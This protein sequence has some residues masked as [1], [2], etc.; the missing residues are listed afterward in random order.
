MEQPVGKKTGNNM[1]RDIHRNDPCP[2]GSGKKYKKCCLLKEPVGH[3]FTTAILGQACKEA[4]KLLMDYA[5]Q[6]SDLFE[7]PPLLG[8]PIPE[9]PQE[10]ARKTLERELWAIWILYLWFPED[11]SPVNL[12]SSRTLAAQFLQD[13]GHRLDAMV[14]RYIEAARTEPFSFWQA[15]S[16]VPETGVCLKDL[17]TGD[18]RFAADRTLSRLATR[19]DIF[20]THVVGLDGQFILNGVG[21]YSLPPFS[22]RQRIVQLADDIRAPGGK[23]PERTQLLRY[24]AELI[25]CY[26]DYVDELLDPPI[27]EIRNKDGHKLVIAKSKYTFPPDQRP[28][29]IET[30]RN[31]RNLVES[32]P[33]NEKDQFVWVGKPKSCSQQDQILK[34]EIAI[35]PD[36]LET[37][38][39]SEMRDKTI[40]RRLLKTFGTIL[41]HE[42]TY[43]E[44][45]RPRKGSG[46]S[47]MTKE[48]K[49]N[50]FDMS[51]LSPEESR[52]MKAHFDQIHMRW[53][54]ES[55]PLLGG[56]TP[57]QVARSP[58]GK[59]QIAAMINDWQHLHQ[60]VQ[61]GPYKFDF[62]KLRA[63]LGIPLLGSALEL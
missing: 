54:D 55:V 61:S 59:E 6:H 28:R 2:C 5:T 43:L 10:D 24:Q 37:E 23:P 57:R 35:G 32:N 9:L 26:F 34:G 53:L 45:F 46:K 8:R 58:K 48:E 7:T 41:T 44:P 4:F 30:L 52:Q 60:R 22:F 39:N 38:C 14:R 11:Y 62:N 19:G 16:V 18:E 21:P 15:E 13:S 27:P 3:R 47:P 36:D 12:P 33:Q 1:N 29:V 56:K 50:L 17:I 51:S 42:S 63:E 49:T 20:F 25:E 31:M 40:R